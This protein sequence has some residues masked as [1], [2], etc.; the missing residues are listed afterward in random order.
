[1][2]LRKIFHFTHLTCYV[3]DFCF[4]WLNFTSSSFHQNLKRCWKRKN[5]GSLGIIS[6]S[7]CCRRSGNKENSHS[8]KTLSCV[9]NHAYNWLL[10]SNSDFYKLEFLWKS[11]T[12]NLICLVLSFLSLCL[13]L[14]NWWSVLTLEE[15]SIKISLFLYVWHN[16]RT[17]GM[18]KITNKA[19][20]RSS[21]YFWS[22]FISRFRQNEASSWSLKRLETKVKNFFNRL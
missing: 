17:L 15:L 7:S 10:F 9:C 14:I 19:S 5:K 1:M 6:K 18:T 13:H 16:A 8:L 20:T 11:F 2:N 3:S 12:F 21:R 22:T 4:P